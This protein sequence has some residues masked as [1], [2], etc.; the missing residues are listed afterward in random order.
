MF[1]VNFV[2]TEQASVRDSIFMLSESLDFS[3]E[4]Q[5]K[6]SWGMNLLI[7]S[8]SKFRGIHEY[9][10]EDRFWFYHQIGSRATVANKSQVVFAF[11]GKF[12]YG[13][14]NSELR[15]PE[16]LAGRQFLG[17]VVDYF[18]DRM[19][20]FCFVDE[21]FDSEYVQVQVSAAHKCA[22]I[23]SLPE[24]TEY[25]VIYCDAL[26]KGLGAMLMQKEKVIAYASQQLKTHEKNYTTRDLELGV[27]ILDQKELNMRQRQWLDLPSDYDCEIR[28]HPENVNVVADALS[29]KEKLI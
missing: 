21:D 22:P 2:H 3:E 5:V 16:K 12:V 27:H 9:V 6:K 10:Y 11:N 7:E 17:V 18:F 4:V 13:F 1:R 25:C 8:G 24:G 19:E 23:I 15:K 28:Y 20:L 29:R 26:H 14:R